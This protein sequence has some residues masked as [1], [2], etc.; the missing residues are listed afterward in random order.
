[1]NP[2]NTIADLVE[3]LKC[4][5]SGGLDGHRSNVRYY[6]RGEPEDYGIT[7]ATPSIGRG[8]R[9]KRETQLFRETERRLP[10]EFASCKS[11][12]EKLVLMQHYQI[13]TRIMDITT[14]ALQAVFFACYNDPDYGMSE[15]K[16]GR[17]DGVVY[18]YEVPEK[19]I[20]NYHA[21]RVSILANIAVCDS[22]NL[23]IRG[24]PAD[25]EHDRKLFN[26]NW[27]IK[28][29]I[30]EIRSEKP[31]FME[32]IKKKDMESIF[33]VHPLLSNPR[34]RAQQGA[35]LI[36]GIDGDKLHLAQWKDET[37][38]MIRRKM[39]IP[40]KAK[41][42]LLKELKMLGLTIDIVYPDWKGSR[43]FLDSKDFLEV[44]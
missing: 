35:F 39:F 10:D 16:Q 36:Y 4:I 22:G 34:I 6:Y 27:K 11:T 7:G 30:H 9:L 13:P 43:Q 2:I 5:E 41:K 40:A 18:V 20:L 26:S 33:C 23:D 12:F 29:L 24:I 14:S 38:G 19:M 15:E 37:D 1:M 8:G 17:K 3:N 42:N 32:W 44:V 25:E 31:Y 28:H 21:D